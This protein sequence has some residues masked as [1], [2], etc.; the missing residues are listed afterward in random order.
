MLTAHWAQ[1]TRSHDELAAADACHSM[2][3]RHESCSSARRI[4]ADDTCVII[5]LKLNSILC[6][7]VCRT[8]PSTAEQQVLQGRFCM[9]HLLPYLHHS[10]SRSWLSAKANGALCCL[11]IPG[12]LIS[13]SCDMPCCLALIMIGQN[14]G[15]CSDAEHAEQLGYLCFAWSV[16]AFHGSM[17]PGHRQ[18]WI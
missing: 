7:I 16:V 12:T 9:S 4:H 18:A 1:S 17:R 13:Q 10:Q 6:K 5:I 14:A 15:G 3:T 2:P 11:L 8:I